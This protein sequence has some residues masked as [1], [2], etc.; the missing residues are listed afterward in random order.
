[1][2]LQVIFRNLQVISTLPKHG[3][4]SR[5]ERG[6][7]HI[8]SDKPVWT[9]VKRFIFN[10]GRAQTL[11]LVTSIIDACSEKAQDL[12]NSKYLDAA[13]TE[14]PTALTAREKLWKLS[15]YLSAAIQ[16]LD[17]LKVSTYS[18]DLFV[19]SQLD[20]MMTRINE[21]TDNISTRLS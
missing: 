12:L 18:R 5:G 10:E 1:M 15:K 11:D 14:D 19:C 9:S 4:L 17:N 16:G 2:S 20:D 13:P 3:K 21:I 7:L 8:E 6:V